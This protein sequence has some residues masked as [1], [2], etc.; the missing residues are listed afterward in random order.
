MSFFLLVP[1]RPPFLNLR[2]L[3]LFRRRFS[4]LALTRQASR[5]VDVVAKANGPPEGTTNAFGDREAGVAKE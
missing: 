4:C 2:M 5:D 1:L 3:S